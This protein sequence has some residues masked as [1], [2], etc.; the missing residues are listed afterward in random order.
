MARTKALVEFVRDQLAALAD[1]VRAA[2]IAA[3]VKSTIP[4]LGVRVPELRAI[5]RRAARSFPPADR[6]AYEAQVR[7]VWAMPHREERHLAV[8]IARVNRGFVDAA[9]MG[10]FEQLIREGAW[11]DFVDEI[12][13]HL[14]GPALLE[15]PDLVWPIVDRWIDDDDMWIRRSAIICQ[16]GAG[17]RT[18]AERLFAYCR[19]RA[20]ER[21]FFV[22]KAIGW[23]LRQYARTSPGAVRAFLARHGDE[24]SPLSRREASKHL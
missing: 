6:A 19:A 4:C 9:S 15:E 10:L 24:L 21:E 2:G 11:W 12:A 3:Y 14:V 1:P 17:P 5:A 16:I 7:A 8:A 20:H 13:T 22:R 23:A 18:D